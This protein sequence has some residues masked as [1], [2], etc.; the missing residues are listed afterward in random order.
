MSCVLYEFY[1]DLDRTNI[2]HLKNIHSPC[3]VLKFVMVK[4]I[5]NMIAKFMSTTVENYNETNA[6]HY[7]PSRNNE[8]R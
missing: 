6:K 2:N 7:L 4:I 8:I 3:N 1:K 5:S